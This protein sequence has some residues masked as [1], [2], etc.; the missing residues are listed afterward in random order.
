MNQTVLMHADID[1]CA[2]RGNV[3]DDT[4]ENHAGLQVG[5]FFDAVL[6]GGGL[7]FGARIAAR[8]FEFFQDVGY[9]RYAEFLVGIFFSAQGFQQLAVAHHRLHVFLYVGEN[10]L[11]QGIGFRM[12]R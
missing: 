4:F 8:F 11:D 12:H 5:E 3:G 2:E 6:K 7:E 10:F 9:G 1:K